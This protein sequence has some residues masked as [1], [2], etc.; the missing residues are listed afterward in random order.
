MGFA[1]DRT[2]LDAPAG[3]RNRTLP[4]LNSKVFKSEMGKKQTVAD[5]TMW[6]H[7]LQ[8]FVW[9]DF[10]AQPGRRYEYVFTPLEGKPGRL[11]AIAGRGPVTIKVRTEPLFSRA[12]H[13]V[14]FNRGVAS[15]QA[16]TAKFGN[17][18]P[19]E[20]P[21]AKRADACTWLA[22][23][24]DTAIVT[25]IRQAK[26]GD[27]LLCCFYEFS[28]LP[29]ATALQT[30][31]KNGVTV[32]IILDGK[33]NG[34]KDKKTGKVGDPFPRH[35]SEQTKAAAKLPDAAVKWREANVN[36]IEHNK[37]M[38][39]LKGKKKTPAELWT[40]STNI[41]SGGIFGQT[42]VGH[43]IRDARVAAAYVRY[44]NVLF[45]DPGAKQG[46]DRATA[47]KARAAYR[48]S[49]EAIAKAPTAIADIKKGIAPVFSPRGGL[50]VLENYA[51]L[52]DTS[53][54]SAAITFAFGVGKEFKDVLQDNT[55]AGPLIFMLLEKADRPAT[56]RAAKSGAKPAKPKAAFVRLNSKNN[57]YEAWGSFIQTPLYQ[58]VRETNTRLL[59]FNQHVLYI[60]TK[61]LLHDPLGNDPIVVTGS[62]NFSKASTQ[63][64][65]ENMVIIRGDTRVADIYFTEFNR[66]F[67]H[68][69]FRSVTE[70]RKGAKDA[71][72]VAALFLDEKGTEW[73]K[74]YAPGSF[75]TKR[76]AVFAGMSGAEVG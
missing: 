55:A 60:H 49:V 40:G 34:R 25:F 27:T 28:Y 64:N 41:S 76:V 58:W 48:K 57:V 39:L 71:R 70:A 68:Y 20:L 61:F 74:Q 46:D 2:D 66:L 23:E 1:I 42:N 73:Q 67:F 6:K 43:W 52:V 12:T 51:R 50:A 22:R 16:Y 35:E 53:A 69:Y 31:R 36:D 13:D 3:A 54:M 33:Q 4:M 19:D 47:N 45:T 17:K 30:A 26:K 11:T 62:A 37:F 38:V 5:K 44:W 21:P 9:D 14:F 8:S 59:Q 56:P 32:R 24:L 29:V 15:S 10:G 18:R 63:N 72:T 75:K 65:D 7:P